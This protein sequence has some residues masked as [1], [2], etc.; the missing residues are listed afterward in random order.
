MAVE[1]WELGKYEKDP[2]LQTTPSYGVQFGFLIP[3]LS[4]LPQNIIHR[5]NAA[6]CSVRTENAA[7]SFF[8]LPFLAQLS[9]ANLE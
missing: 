5:L 1:L 8:V 3:A 2:D 9:P 7:C 4:T 6:L